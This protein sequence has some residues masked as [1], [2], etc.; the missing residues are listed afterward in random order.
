MKQEEMSKVV[1]EKDN[2]I[3]R[4]SMELKQLQEKGTYILS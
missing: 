2:V 4:A 3:R 1:N